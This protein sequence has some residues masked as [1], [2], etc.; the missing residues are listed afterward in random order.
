ML[1]T[2]LFN[3]GYFI[4]VERMDM[5]G[6]TAEQALSRSKLA[7]LDSVIPEAQ[8]EVAEILISGTVTEFEPDKGS[9]IPGIIGKTFISQRWG[10]SHIA[11]DL[12]VVDV[13]SGRILVEKRIPGLAISF[14]ASIAGGV[15]VGDIA[16]PVSL[17]IYRNTPM[18]YAIRDCVQ[19]IAMYVVNGIPEVYY[20]HR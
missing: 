3:S 10:E 20:R 1:I 14:K 12:R 6:L 2:A 5:E 13:A 7:R 18:E 8:M 15:P 11:M 16:L 4:V 17:G 9:W 19:K